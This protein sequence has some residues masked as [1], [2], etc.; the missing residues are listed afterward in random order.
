MHGNCDLVQLTLSILLTRNTSLL[1]II[2]PLSKLN[3]F[4]YYPKCPLN[5]WRPDIYPKQNSLTFGVIYFS[6]RL[7]VLLGFRFVGRCRNIV[8][9]C[10]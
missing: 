2:Q 9:E 8:S 10:E 1:N 5:A 7:N 6:E 3:T 4:Y